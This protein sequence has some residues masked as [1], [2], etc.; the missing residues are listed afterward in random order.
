MTTSFDFL[1]KDFLV[2]ANENK[3]HSCKEPVS[4][5]STTK[6]DFLK[7]YRKHYKSALESKS[8]SQSKHNKNVKTE[9]LPK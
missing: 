9:A 7:T 2:K 5:P 8:D 3:D 4:A 6:K 1:N